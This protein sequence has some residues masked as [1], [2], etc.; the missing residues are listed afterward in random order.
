MIVSPYFVPGSKL[1]DYL[2]GLESRGVEVRILTNSLA[3]NDV[4]L[5]HAGYMRYRERLVSGGVDLYEFKPID[6]DE[7]PDQLIS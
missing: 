4:S 5:V 7:L 2:V 3:S 1:S 6:V